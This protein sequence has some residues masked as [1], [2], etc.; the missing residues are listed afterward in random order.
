MTPNNPTST[1]TYHPSTMRGR[2]VSATKRVIL[3]GVR[4]QMDFLSHSLEWHNYLQL[5]CRHSNP[6]ISSSSTGSNQEISVYFIKKDHQNLGSINIYWGLSLN[7]TLTVSF[8]NV[9]WRLLEALNLIENVWKTGILKRGR[10]WPW[11]RLTGV[12]KSS[13]NCVV[14]AVRIAITGIVFM[15]EKS[16]VNW[17]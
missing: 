2:D 8:S 16:S 5:N 4:S 7:F 13:R 3:V 11:S 12:V 1:L 17:L 14:G 6:I 15:Q 9:R 10:K